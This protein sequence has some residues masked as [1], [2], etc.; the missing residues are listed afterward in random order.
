[1]SVA[2]RMREA[3]EAGDAEGLRA[4]LQADPQAAGAREDGG[5]SPLLTALYHGRRDLAELILAHGRDPDAAEAAALGDVDR[6]RAALDA[7]PGVIT[8][9]TH[10]GWT[11][12]HL[13][14]FFGH[15]DAARLLLERGSDPRAISI[16]GMRNTPLHAALAGPM[17]IEGVRMLVEAGADVHARQHGGFTP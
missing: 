3:V 7:E 14:G 17:A 9:F 1:M 12:L 16:N 15:A 5:E 10:D 13:A 4:I 6:L 11:L 8:R 2:T